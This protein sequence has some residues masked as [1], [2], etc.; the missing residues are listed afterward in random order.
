[1]AVV[2]A[3]CDRRGWGGEVVYTG[4]EE[5][6]ELRDCPDCG[7]RVAV[8]PRADEVLHVETE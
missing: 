8:D 7:G 4:V 2:E 1:M 3:E 5:D 6:G